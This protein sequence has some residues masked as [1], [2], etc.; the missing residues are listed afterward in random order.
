MKRRIA[1]ILWSAVLAG[2]TASGALAAALLGPPP[3][4]G[5]RLPEGQCIILR[6][7]GPHRVVDKN[8]LLMGA[9]GKNRG[10]YRFT[11]TNGCLM[12]AISSDPIG[13]SQVSHGGTIC[14]P[15]DV[16]LQ[17]RS[18]LCAID[19]IVK[20][21]PDEVRNLPRQLKP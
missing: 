10:V 20:L 5:T 14:A 11:M 13:L 12:S 18:G 8:T 3:P 1:S 4:S 17:A 2:S 15:R 6:A 16:T 9:T 19:S 21:T 7:A